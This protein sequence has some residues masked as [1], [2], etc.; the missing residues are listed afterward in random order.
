M[1][2]GIIAYLLRPRLPRLWIRCILSVLTCGSISRNPQLQLRDGNITWSVDRLLRLYPNARLPTLQVSSLSF[3]IYGVKLGFP[4]NNVCIEGICVPY[5]E[6][7]P[8]NRRIKLSVGSKHHICMSFL[9]SMHENQLYWLCQNLLQFCEAEIDFVM[10]TNIQGI[11]PGHT[12]LEVC[13]GQKHDFSL[14][15]FLW[16]TRTG[17]CDLM[18]VIPDYAQSVVG[19]YADAQQASERAQAFLHVGSRYGTR[20]PPESPDML[21]EGM[22]IHIPITNE[23]LAC[24]AKLC[25]TATTLTY[26]GFLWLVHSTHGPITLRK[27]RHQPSGLEFRS[28]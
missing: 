16:K 8:K 20:G 17:V 7:H 13:P 1:S 10:A 14:I 19:R 3:L 6:A 24:A 23:G 22:K 9:Y 21:M 4:N 12:Q 18:C 27:H 11:Y 2:N 26:D 15:F 5:M 28:L 25:N